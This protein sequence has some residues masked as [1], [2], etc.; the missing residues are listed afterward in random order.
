MDGSFVHADAPKLRWIGR[1]R[2]GIA[3]HSGT[4]MRLG[5]LSGTFNPP[6]CAH[7]QLAEAAARQLAL[8]EVLLVVPEIP[9][10]KAELA[11]GLADRAEML[12]RAVAGQRRFSAAVSTHGLLVDIHYALAP[13][14]PPATREYFLLGGDAAE[15]IL[16]RWPYTHRAEALAEMF[17]YFE[18]AVADRGKRFELPAHDLATR[19]AGKIHSLALPPEWELVSASRARC[20]AA[21]GAS[22]DGVVVPEVAEYIALHGLYQR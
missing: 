4:A 3:S 14:Y 8:D 19:Y 1:A 2:D 22:L 13:H 20:L 16:L 15:R 5:V 9:P 21:D 7:L 18:F 17:A 12:R 10:H 6:T 11:A